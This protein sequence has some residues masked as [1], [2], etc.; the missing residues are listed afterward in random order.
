[1]SPLSLSLL[2]TPSSLCAIQAGHSELFSP[3]RPVMVPIKR[4]LLNTTFSRALLSPQ[5]IRSSSGNRRRSVQSYVKASEGSSTVASHGN[6]SQGARKNMHNKDSTFPTGFEVGEFE[7][8]I[9]RDVGSTNTSVSNALPIFSPSTAPPIPS[10]PMSESNPAPQSAA[11]PPKPSSAPSSPFAYVSS[12]K[13][14][15]LAA[16]EASGSSGY[17]LVS[18][19]TVGSFR[20]GRTVNGKKQP[21]SCKEGAEIK[22]GQVIGYLDQFGN[23]LPIKSDVAGEVLKILFKDGEPVGYGDPIVAVLPS[24]HGI[25]K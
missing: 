18:S 10:M 17:A 9:K 6:T 25:N 2:S 19:P 5:A 7:M 16:L 4:V 20:S 23:E 14:S 21:P 1:M 15:K 3:Q 8:H 12:V 13:E 11:L 22:E 24:F